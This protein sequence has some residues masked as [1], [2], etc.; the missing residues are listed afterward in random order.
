[1]LRNNLKSYNSETLQHGGRVGTGGR[2][3]SSMMA[4][5]HVNQYSTMPIMGGGNGTNAS[6]RAAS[7]MLEAGV[8]MGGGGGGPT[9]YQTTTL[10]TFTKRG[11]RTN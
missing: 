2:N 5:G 8:A 3:H 6:N 10:S 4:A 1:M 7:K 11:K 9:I